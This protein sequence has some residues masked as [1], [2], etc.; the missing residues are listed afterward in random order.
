L[1]FL[2]R[3]S[4]HSE[5]AAFEIGHG[6]SALGQELCRSEAEARLIA[7]SDIERRVNEKRD[8]AERSTLTQRR[9]DCE[10]VEVREAEI[11]DDQARLMDSGEV[12][13]L[14]AG[15]RV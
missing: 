4:K 10:A 8:M 14:A 13:G 11:E 1:P 5:N 15:H 7:G 3:R 6:A 12:N 9:D 2:T